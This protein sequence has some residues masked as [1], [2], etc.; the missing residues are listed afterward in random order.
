MPGNVFQGYKSAVRHTVRTGGCCAQHAQVDEEAYGGLEGRSP[1]SEAD[2]AKPASIIMIGVVHGAGHEAGH[3]AGHG[4]G[5]EAGH[6]AGHGARLRSLLKFQWMNCCPWCHPLARTT[7][8]ESR[9]TMTSAVPI[10]R[11]SRTFIRRRKS[12]VSV[13]T[14]SRSR[15][16]VACQIFMPPPSS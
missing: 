4:A 15:T 8:M 6:G 3:E 16:H 10:S 13:H 2:I 11:R 5:H 12:F 14:H 1:R 7:W 9:G